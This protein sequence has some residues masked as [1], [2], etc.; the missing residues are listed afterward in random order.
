MDSRGNHKINGAGFILKSYVV[1]NLFSE[2]NK[3]KDWPQRDR[4]ALVY[5]LRKNDA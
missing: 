2:F 3:K 1:A 5:K 4:F